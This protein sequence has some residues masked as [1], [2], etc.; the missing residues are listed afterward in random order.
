MAGVASE[1]RGEC[2]FAAFNSVRGYVSSDEWFKGTE[3]IRANFDLGALP[4]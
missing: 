3:I 1:N 2:N 4:I